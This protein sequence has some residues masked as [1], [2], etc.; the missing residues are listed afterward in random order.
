M[1]RYLIA[2]LTVLAVLGVTP[3]RASATP[4]INAS[5]NAAFFPCGAGG[6]SVVGTAT[7]SGS[8]TNKKDYRIQWHV[9][10][11]QIKGGNSDDVNVNSTKRAFGT[12]LSDTFNRTTQCDEWGW[13]EVTAEL[14]P[15]TGT[16]ILQ[17]VTL[18]YENKYRSPLSLAYQ[19]ITHWPYGS[20][21]G[22]QYVVYV[23]DADGR[24]VLDIPL[25]FDVTQGSLYDDGTDVTTGAPGGGGQG[26]VLLTGGP[27]HNGI[28]DFEVAHGVFE[29]DG[30]VTLLQPFLFRFAEYLV[31]DCP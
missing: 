23:H 19:N 31:N 10:G 20:C 29:S 25:V 30:S 7:I 21:A 27:Y 22:W 13:F 4:T 3:L 14:Y 12:D 16:N 8:E 6:N 5:L 28:A 2:V 15:P 1:K 18:L 17:T 26:L 9:D 11:P 24:Q